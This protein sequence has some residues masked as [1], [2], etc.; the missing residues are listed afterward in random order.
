MLQVVFRFTCKF[1]T[2]LTLGCILKMSSRNIQKWKLPHSAL[3]GTITVALA[4]I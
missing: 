3:D 1:P 2:L 4:L